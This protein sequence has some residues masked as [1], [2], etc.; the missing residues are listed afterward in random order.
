MAFSKQSITWNKFYWGVSNDDKLT[1]PAQVL[2][3]ENLDLKRNSEFVM[4]NPYSTEKVLTNWKDI[5]WFINVSQDTWNQKTFGWW[6]DGVIYYVLWTDNVPDYTAT[7]A[8]DIVNA[9]EFNDYTYFMTVWPSTTDIKYDKILSDNMYDLTW[10]LAQTTLATWLTWTQAD[11]Y[12]MYNYLDAFLYIWVWKTVYREDSAW[13]QETFNLWTAD[14][15]WITQQWW[16]FKLYQSD[17][18]VI[19]WDGLSESA[20]SVVNINDEIRTVISHQWIDYIVW[21]ASWFYSQLYFMNWYKAELIQ[22]WIDSQIPNSPQSD[23]SSKFYIKWD[24]WKLITFDWQLLM[25][26]QDWLDSIYSFWNAKQ[27][28]PK[29]F[30]QIFYV[31]PDGT[32]ADFISWLGNSTSNTSFFYGYSYPASAIWNFLADDSTYIRTWSMI[33]PIFDAW[34]K[35]TKKKIEEIRVYAQDVSSL[36]TLVIKAS[37]DWWAFGTIWTVTSDWRTEIYS[38]VSN[39]YDIVFQIDFDIDWAATA[40]YGNNPKLYELKLIYTVIED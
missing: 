19:F 15:V 38:E 28:F 12:P 21:W 34:T 7:S 8:S 22:S 25:I 35:T 5:D 11:K 27:W 13:V 14:I 40:N 17:G 9:I 31:W 2:Y 16:V 1:Q 3:A 33:L 29:W 18:R 32:S 37:I 30:E 20:D 36:S 24:I 10:A 26:N 4:L 6:E 23:R 39:F